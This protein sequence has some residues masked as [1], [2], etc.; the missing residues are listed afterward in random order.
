[1]TNQTTVACYHAGFSA[2]GCHHMSL[3]WAVTQDPQ[4]MTLRKR[5]ELQQRLRKEADPLV[6][7]VCGTCMH[8]CMMLLTA[9]HPRYS[10]DLFAKARKVTLQQLR[11]M[12]LTKWHAEDDAQQ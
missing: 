3:G 11:E 12:L 7:D 10:S 4:S 8:I 2:S 9:S 5:S 1:M 6:A